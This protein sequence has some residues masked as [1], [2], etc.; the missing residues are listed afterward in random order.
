MKK[1]EKSLEL[2]KKNE[3][4]SLGWSGTLVGG[5]GIAKVLRT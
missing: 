3:T 1:F 2:L 4:P 5:G